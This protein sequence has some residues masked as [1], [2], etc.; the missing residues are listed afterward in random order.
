MAIKP[1]STE[2]R[3]NEMV[4]VKGDAPGISIEYIEP[5]NE[6]AI[7]SDTVIG[8][9]ADLPA[10]AGPA[11]ALDAQSTIMVD[12]DKPQ[13]VTE[14]EPILVAAAGPVKMFGKAVKEMGQGGALK[15]QKAI[16]TPSDPSPGVSAEDLKQSEGA[17]ERFEQTLEQTPAVGA[18]PDMAIN[19]DRIDGPDD[20]KQTVNALADST[21]V[22]DYSMTWEQTRADAVAKGIDPRQLQD[23]DAFR[24]RY[25]DLPADLVQLRLAAIGNSRVTYDAMRRAYTNPDDMNAQAEVLYLINKQ[26]MLNDSYTLVRTRSAQAT[27]AGRM[28][29]TEG[30][31]QDFLSESADVKLPAANSN[32]IRSILSDPTASENLKYMIEKYIQL[33]DPLAQE[34]ML[35]QV[36]KVGLVRDLIDRSWK[37][38]LLSATGT[39]VV[40]LTSNATFLL[41]TVATRQM[42]GIISTL[43]RGAG[44]KGEVEFGEAASMVAGM[45]H[46]QRDALSLAW[47]A[48]RTGTNI[49]MRR[50]TELMSDAGMR[51]EGQYRLFNARDY[52]VENEI[53]IKGINGY[54]NFT[55]LLGGRPIMGMDEYF[56][57]VGYRAELYAQAYRAQHQARREAIAAKKTPEEAEQAG[58]NAMESVLRD[59]SPEIAATAQ[60]FSHMITFSK[61]LTG[62]SA[63]VQELAKD[64]LL[65]RI[66]LPFVKAPIW[67]GSE[68][69][70]HSYLA[71]LSKQ[72]RSDMAAGGAKR[73]LAI[74]KFGMG[75]AL[76][77][78]VGSM[79]ID[80]RITGGGPGNTSLRQQYMAQGWRPYSFVFRES[81][82]D[83]EFIDDLKEYGLDPSISGDGLLYVPYRGFDPL[84]GPL[85]IIA[86][87]VEYARYEDDTD[88]VS[89][90][91]MGS[92][93]GLY[94]Y[95][96][97]QPV[98]TGIA[99][100]A[101]AF[102]TEIPNPKMAFKNAID[103][104]VKQGATYV[105]GLVPFQSARN[106]LSRSLDPEKRDV[107]GDPYLSTGVKGLD[108]YL[109][110]MYSITPGL[111][112]TLPSTHDYLG[113]PEY[114]GDPA[115]PWTSSAS[116]IRYSAERQ[117]EADR[118]INN[119]Q[120]PLQK[121]KPNIAVPTPRGSV[122]VKLTPE[123]HQEL[124]RNL[125]M[126]AGPAIVENKKTGEYEVKNVGVEDAIVAKAAEPGF[127]RA[128][129]Y[130]Q[131][132]EIKDVYSNYVQAAKDLL[133][134]ANPQ[135]VE[136][137]I[138]AA[139]EREIY[140]IPQ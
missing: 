99:S 71:P 42:A 107:R 66:I 47:K 79:V 115:N 10:D 61:K 58:L 26:K 123:E 27:A 37:N 31:I 135:I 105:T 98:M 20:F 137:G 75:S 96:G 73:E 93:W 36:G 9:M 101:G 8:N 55:S 130:T 88:L 29:I 24:E 108:E 91:L 53:M 92:T 39:H 18:P 131:Q 72:W 104:I 77:T 122:S 32:E 87:T 136:R 45:I 12:E 51:Y 82:W 76:M 56:K 81:E 11:D 57:T 3:L 97:Q 1:K 112:Q 80:G 23:L 13:N 25:G 19:V 65:G 17:L 113:R 140:G 69:L 74:A 6:K 50:G 14:D 103:G 63:T 43:K 35:I 133:L 86:D 124:L 121:P 2:A 30:M 128:T 28:Q 67:L 22:R 106:Q 41:S 110:Y 38:G 139:V 52:G 129:R 120:V 100:I 70:Q 7:K 5:I 16:P 15:Q 84:S 89:Q 60:D 119:L 68:S 33:D 40:N 116:G 21:G 4:T 48:V 94:N 64:T 59:P 62:H 49:E 125:S 46:A 83:E 111:S 132:Q 118:I 126:V 54:A 44:G 102:T 34:D 95:I 127:M 134:R 78:S 85:A 109:N 117:A 90:V 138:S 114:R